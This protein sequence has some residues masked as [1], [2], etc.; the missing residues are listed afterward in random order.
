MSVFK[1]SFKN[2][3]CKGD[4][5]LIVRTHEY[6]K[7]YINKAVKYCCVTF[8]INFTLNKHNRETKRKRE[9][10]NSPKFNT[11]SERY[12]KENYFGGTKGCMITS[13]NSIIDSMSVAR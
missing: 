9:R 4:V 3:I 13:Q 10:W 7:Y 2:S 11:G 8:S 5:L 12:W 6:S 1:Q